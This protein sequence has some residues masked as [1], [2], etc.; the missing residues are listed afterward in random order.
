VRAAV[1]RG[2]GH[3]GS[4]RALP[5]LQRLLSDP[6]RLVRAE[7]AAAAGRLRLNETAPRLGQILAQ[8][9]YKGARVA[10]ARALCRLPPELGLPALGPAAR[11]RQ[12]LPLALVAGA[13]LARH[14][15]DQP[16]LNAIAMGLVDR[17]WTVRVAACNAATAVG[18]RVARAL[19][20]PALRDPEPRV[21]VAA[22]RALHQQRPAEASRTLRS[23]HALTCG[24]RGPASVCLQA[25]E[26]L[27]AL[28]D[29][30]GRRTLIRLARRAQQAPRRVQ[31]LRAALRAG[32]PRRL[33]VEALADPSPQVVLAAAAWLY[34][35]L[36]H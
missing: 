18:Q 1:A 3:T 29:G 9:P 6:D 4:P 30:Q 36:P 7:A 12:Q 16:L 17:R 15:Q 5:T 19:T 13:C 33:A 35:D 26:L 25:A 24:P 31:A 21:R 11:D 23:L 32:V 34:R 22:A 14:G 27:L 2:A 8:D 10:A 28:G 20:L